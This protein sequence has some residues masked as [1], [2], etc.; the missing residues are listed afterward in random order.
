MFKSKGEI[1]TPLDVVEK[2]LRKADLVTL[3]IA[4]LLLVMWVPAGRLKVLGYVCVTVSSILAAAS[5]TRIGRLTFRLIA[6]AI[7][8][9]VVPFIK[10]K[11]RPE[12]KPHQLVEWLTKGRIDAGVTCHEAKNF[13]IRQFKGNL[14][15]RDTCRFCL[16]KE[17]IPDLFL[18]IIP[19]RAKSIRQIHLSAYEVVM[20]EGELSPEAMFEQWDSLGITLR[21]DSRDW[22]KLQQSLREA[23]NFVPQILT[24]YIPIRFPQEARIRI[25]PQRVH[26]LQD[27]S[28]LIFGRFADTFENDKIQRD[29]K[30]WLSIPIC[31]AWEA[32]G[33]RPDFCDYTNDAPA[34]LKELS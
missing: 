18:W 33:K 21:M 17:R 16:Q 12:W 27:G 24:A 11:F 25:Q 20:K 1:K 26:R 32:Q 6:N 29:Q 2:L 4:W 7:N 10:S 22:S 28:T 15:R 23:Y 8:D 3:P 31:H 30:K 5:R 34:R 14:C 9:R 19:R 13:R